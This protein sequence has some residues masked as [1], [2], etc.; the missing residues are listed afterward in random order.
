MQAAAASVSVAT[1]SRSALA[2][3][4]TDLM[5]QVGNTSNLILDPDSL[6]VMD[7]LVAQLPRA[8]L[9][10]I[11]AAAPDSQ[12]HRGDLIAFQAVRA[13]SILE[14]TVGV[15]SDTSMAEANTVTIGLSD[16]LRLALAV[17]D[18]ASALATNMIDTINKTTVGGV[19]AGSV[20]AAAATAI[21]PTIGALSSLLDARVGWLTDQR[22]RTLSVSLAV[23]LLAGWVVA[24]LWCPT[25][26]DVG[27]LVSAVLALADDDLG[28]RP[29][30]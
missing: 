11:E 6:Y 8:T 1:S 29:L 3:A 30:P 13:G 18:N 9:A 26:N 25:C 2:G 28:E 23:A 15:R 21:V 20:G 27:L 24:A 5:T 19:E 17:A 12:L 4:L 7:T 10:A 14:A 16:T 22:N